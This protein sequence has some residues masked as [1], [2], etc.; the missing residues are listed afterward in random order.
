[1]NHG[2]NPFAEG[3]LMV[4]SVVANRAIIMKILKSKPVIKILKLSAKTMATILIDE[5]FRKKR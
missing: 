1:M 5:A 3:G 4:R 2:D